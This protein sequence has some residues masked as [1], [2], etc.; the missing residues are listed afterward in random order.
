M[1]PS[2]P[3]SVAVRPVRTP[4]TG[5]GGP[6]RRLVLRLCTLGLLSA[7][8]SPVLPQEGRPPADAPE[9][10]PAV[11]IATE[12]AFPPF[13]F[14]DPKGEPQGFEIELG[15]AL[16]AAARRTCT[17]VVQD[18]DG[19]IPGLLEGRYDAIMASLAIKER[20]KA[21]IAFTK[22]YYRIP[23][24]FLGQKDSPLTDTSPPALVHRTIGTV[25]RSE[26]ARFLEAVHPEAQ[27]MLYDKLESANLD[28]LAGRIDLVLGDRLALDRFLATREGGCC[29]I[30]AELPWSRSFYGDGVGIGLRKEDVGLREAFDRAIDQVIAT[31]AYDRIR[32]RY[33]A[34]STR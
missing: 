15:R 2:L 11:R 31:G 1:T 21:R 17:F 8:P 29:R 28:L 3:P 18:W 16:C 5:G 24:A 22:P 26:H 20:R 30:I 19:L 14:L 33:L 23:A 10:L 13:N 25:A 12:G 9:T 4:V 32:A 7:L 34:F 27:V 6:S